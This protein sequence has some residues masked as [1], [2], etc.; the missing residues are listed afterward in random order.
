MSTSDDESDTTKA[1]IPLLRTEERTI[2]L[3][4]LRLNSNGKKNDFNYKI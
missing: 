4:N 1:D 3:P 2:N